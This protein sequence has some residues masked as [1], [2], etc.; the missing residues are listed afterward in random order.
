MTVHLNYLRQMAG[1]EI[2]P[3]I[4]SFLFQQP[5]NSQPLSLQGMARSHWWGPKV[6]GVFMLK[7]FIILIWCWL[8]N[9]CWARS[10]EDVLYTLCSGS[11]CSLA[12]E[13]GSRLGSISATSLVPVVTTGRVWPSERGDKTPTSQWVSAE[14]QRLGMVT[15]AIATEACDSSGWELHPQAYL[16][17]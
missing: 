10:G 1:E 12:Q 4:S 13:F 5:L 3:V 8:L 16:S 11:P 7:L 2:W 9:P 15:S 14:G 6:G 17:L